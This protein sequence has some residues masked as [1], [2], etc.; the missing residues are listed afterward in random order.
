[1]K[2]KN[3]IHI[4]VVSLIVAVNTIVLLVTACIAR[5]RIQRFHKAIETHRANIQKS[6]EHRLQVARVKGD[7]KLVH[8]LEAEKKYYN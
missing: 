7:E 1:M 2:S 6:L 8:Q 4:R 5:L 3:D